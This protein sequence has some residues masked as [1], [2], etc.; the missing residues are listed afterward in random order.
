MPILGFGTWQLKEVECVTATTK[1]L[2]VGYRHIDTADGYH[3]H[4]AVGTAI[5]NSSVDRADIF[6]TT[7]VWQSDFGADKTGA[8]IDRFL[9]E[10]K[11]TILI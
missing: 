6:L 11:L 4:E 3:N 1:A 7:K 2:E 9:T 8:A 5:K 10:L